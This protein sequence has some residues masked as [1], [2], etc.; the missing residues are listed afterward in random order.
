MALGANNGAV[1]AQGSGDTVRVEFS[2]P[3]WTCLEIQHILVHF[4]LQTEI[5]NAGGRI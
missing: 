3:G 1:V 4:L 2:L 5:S